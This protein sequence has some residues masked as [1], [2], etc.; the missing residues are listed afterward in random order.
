MT[1]HVGFYEMRYWKIEHVL[2]P[3]LFYSALPTILE[4][5]AVFYFSSFSQREESTEFLNN[6]LAPSHLIEPVETY[7]SSEP[8][9][10]SGHFLYTSAMQ[11]DLETY[12]GEW[13]TPVADNI[14]CY[15]RGKLLLWFHDAL[16][17]GDLQLADSFTKE[18]VSKFCAAM[19]P[20]FEL[21]PP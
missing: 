11:K 18:Q 2:S 16:A 3:Q 19:S 7:A 12:F 21:M 6:H 15:H 17:W 20:T 13:N 10:W 5:G 1:T 14:V 9:R 4:E 8:A